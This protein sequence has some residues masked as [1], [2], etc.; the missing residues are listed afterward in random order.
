MSMTIGQNQNIIRADYKAQAQTADPIKEE[1]PEKSSSSREKTA[2]YEHVTKDGDTL[3]LSTAGKSK[4]PISDAQLASFS[5]SR[6]KQL[7]N[8]KEITK[9]QYDKALKNRVK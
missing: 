6:I 9:Q 1:T 2:G 7:Y 4:I 3:E 8:R 5:E